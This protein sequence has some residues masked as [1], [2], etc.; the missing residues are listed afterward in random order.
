MNLATAFDLRPAEGLTPKLYFSCTVPHHEALPF[1]QG[2]PRRYPSS[3]SSFSYSSA[4]GDCLQLALLLMSSEGRFHQVLGMPVAA[5][6]FVFRQLVLTSVATPVAL[7]AV[8][9]AMM[10]MPVMMMPVI[11]AILAISGAFVSLPRYLLLPE[12]LR[13]LPR[14]LPPV[15][16]L[17]L[18]HDVRLL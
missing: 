4:Q 7:V 16:G 13:A 10:M 1:V 2:Q 6:M 14:H 9:G 18:H 12:L 17:D 15:P 11:R 5:F 3:S 8:S